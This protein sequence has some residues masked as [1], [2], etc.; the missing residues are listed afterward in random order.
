MTSN[1]KEEKCA[2]KRLK[3]L[4]NAEICGIIE[5]CGKNNVRRFSFGGLVITFGENGVENI[6]YENSPVAK[7]E[8]TRK[9]DTESLLQDEIAIREGQLAMMDVTDPVQYEKLLE[10]GELTNGKQKEEETG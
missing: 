10:Q 7:T 8:S 3:N 1:K 6:Q 9:V 2:C 4:T 5:A